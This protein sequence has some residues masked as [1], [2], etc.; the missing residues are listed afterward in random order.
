MKSESN[1]EAVDKK[2]CS[3]SKTNTALCYEVNSTKTPQPK[4]MS[5]PQTVVSQFLKWTSGSPPRDPPTPQPLRSHSG[6]AYT[7]IYTHKQACKKSGRG[8]V[9]R[10]QERPLVGKRHFS[11]VATFRA[12]SLQACLAS[13][14]LGVHCRKRH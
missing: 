11:H 8:K 1:K 5:V 10:S 4:K 7:H 13:H 3:A 14:D 2:C 6:H 12:R 9:P